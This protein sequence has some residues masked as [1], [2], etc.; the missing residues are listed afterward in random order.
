MLKTGAYDFQELKLLDGWQ[1]FSPRSCT[2]KYV[3]VNHIIKKGWQIKARVWRTFWCIWIEV[4]FQHKDD[5]PATVWELGTAQWVF[6]IRDF[7]W[8]VCFP[9]C[10]ICKTEWISLLQRYYYFQTGELQSA[11]VY[12]NWG[13]KKT[14]FWAKVLGTKLKLKIFCRKTSLEN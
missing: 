7:A 3:Q 12:L 8:D 14:L 13:K 1:R 4:L 9:R 5:I 6:Y 2:M 10:N 11:L